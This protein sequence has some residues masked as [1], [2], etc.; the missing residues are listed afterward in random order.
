MRA[1]PRYAGLGIAEFSRSGALSL[2]LSL[3]PSCIIATIYPG[4]KTKEQEITPTISTLPFTYTPLFIP[5]CNGH[6]LRLSSTYITC[7]IQAN[8]RHSATQP[9]VFQRLVQASGLQALPQP[10]PLHHPLLGTGVQKLYGAR[11]QG[12]HMG[13]ITIRR[14]NDMFY[15]ELR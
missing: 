3:S 9:F 14:T 12:M 4:N 1:S 15:M 7:V 6:I 8:M 5:K 11:T 13:Y 2:S 10:A